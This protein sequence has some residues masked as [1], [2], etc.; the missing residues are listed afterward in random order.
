MLPIAAIL[1]RTA[2]RPWPLPSAPWRGFMRWTDLAFL[3]WPVPRGALEPHL[4]AGLE[5]DTFDQQAWIGVVPFRMEGVRHRWLPPIP[6]AGSFAEINVRTYVRSGDRAGVWFLSLDAESWLAVRGARFGF[7]LPYFDAEMQ[8]RRDG[9]TVEYRSTRTHRNAATAEFRAR[10]Q[11]TSAP[12]TARPGTLDHWLTER[13]CLFGQTR[14]GQVYHVDVHHVPW[15]LQEAEA[16]IDENTMTEAGG[17][18]LAGAAPLV[19]VVSSLD[20]LAWS[21]VRL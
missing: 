16:T 2:H 10:Y 9:S 20:V 21:P 11:P 7:N 12:Y 15:P 14:S 8:V 18:P 17:V 13:Y 5:L 3:H 6:T 19:H 1:D 4:P